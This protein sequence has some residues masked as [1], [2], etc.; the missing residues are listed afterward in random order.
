M[1]NIYK[2]QIPLKDLI[3][4]FLLNVGYSLIKINIIIRTT[5]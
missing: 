5:R 4:L 2:I 3:R 1:K